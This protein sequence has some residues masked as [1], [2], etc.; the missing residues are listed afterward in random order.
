MGAL[1]RPFLAVLAAPGGQRLHILHRLPALMASRRTDR[2]RRLLFPLRNLDHGPGRKKL[3]LRNHRGCR[4]TG[5]VGI[6]W[7]NRR[8]RLSVDG[9]FRFPL[10]AHFGF[11][12]T[13]SEVR[14][15]VQALEAERNQQSSEAPEPRCSTVG[16]FAHLVRRLGSNRLEVKSGRRFRDG[17][18]RG[19]PPLFR[20][21]ISG[22]GRGRWGLWHLIRGGSRSWHS[23]RCGRRGWH[24]PLNWRWRA[25]PRL[26][27]R[28]RRLRRW[29]R[30][31]VENGR[32]RLWGS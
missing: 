16:P 3:R 29:R 9:T 30:R 1:L 10:I 12:L 24:C 21:A 32:S 2:P 8:E 18:R 28:L 27:H 11:G 31:G 5:C 19:S 7:R 20:S 22:S 23:G 14:F 6:D 4:G 13:V 26:R 15:L 25:V 17:S